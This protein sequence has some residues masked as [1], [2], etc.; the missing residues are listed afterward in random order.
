MSLTYQYYRTRINTPYASFFPF[1]LSSS[2]FTQTVWPW[3]RSIVATTPAPTQ[4][5][6]NYQTYHIHQ[7][8]KA[9][10]FTISIHLHH[11]FFFFPS[12]RTKQNPTYHGTSTTTT[13]KLNHTHLNTTSILIRISA[14]DATLCLFLTYDELFPSYNHV[15]TRKYNQPLFVIINN[16]VVL[17]YRYIDR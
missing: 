13:P 7:S 4:I 16:V 11:Y 8:I 6:T 5:S 2:R 9:K 14:L 12:S 15:P 17:S 1:L 10:P 3:T